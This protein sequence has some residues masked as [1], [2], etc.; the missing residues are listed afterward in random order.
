MDLEISHFMLV[1]PFSAL[2]GT[3]G[4]TT[5]LFLPTAGGILF[6][7]LCVYTQNAQNVMENSDMTDNVKKNFNPS[8]PLPGMPLLATAWG[9]IFSQKKF[10]P[11]HPG[12]GGRLHRF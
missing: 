6:S 12:G 2:L 4:A 7:T 10:L 8:L 9:N 3:K 1:Q 11:P 5:F